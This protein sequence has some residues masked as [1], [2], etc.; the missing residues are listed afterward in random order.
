M[1]SSG[2]GK[3]RKR[4]YCKCAYTAK[5]R[6]KKMHPGGR[7]K[8]SACGTEAD[9]EDGA[10][11]GRG[12]AGLNGIHR[13]TPCVRRISIAAAYVHNAMSRCLHSDR[14]SERRAAFINGITNRPGLRRFG[15]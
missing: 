11:S 6:A 2:R 7:E 10:V 8:I 4:E 5:R 13:R 1:P 12:H 14:K 3:R 15:G 9:G